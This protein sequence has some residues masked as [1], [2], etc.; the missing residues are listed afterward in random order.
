MR[1]VESLGLHRLDHGRGRWCRRG[2]HPDGAGERFREPGGRLGDGGEDDGGTAE[3][4]HPARVDGFED[5]VALHPAQTDVRAAEGSDGPRE[6]PAVAV[7]HRQRPQVDGIVAEFPDQLVVHRGEVGAAV[8]VDHAL[9]MA[10]G[11]RRVV[12]ADGLPLIV[13]H[14]HAVRRRAGAGD[15]FVVGADRLRSRALGIRRPDHARPLGRRDVREGRL[16]KFAVLGVGEHQ[17]GAAV[18]QNVPDRCG[19]KAG[20]D[21]VQHGTRHRHGVVA[22]EHCRRVGE[23]RGHGVARPDS[24][25]LQPG[26]NAA[27]PRQEFRVRGGTAPMHPGEPLGKDI[28]ASQQEPQRGER[29]VVHRPA[30]QVAHVGMLC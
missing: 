6:T 18:L 12:E 17:P 29:L 3:M 24:L 7:E 25:R 14:A 13:R 11:A 5:R 10:G 19:I 23:Q 15:V 22:L 30:R 27:A 9:R 8:V 16:D 20:V 21:R 28:R 26:R 1:D 2:H 4:R